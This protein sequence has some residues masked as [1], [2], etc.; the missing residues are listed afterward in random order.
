[1]LRVPADDMEMGQSLSDCFAEQSLEFAADGA[2]LAST[3]F[4]DVYTTA[5]L[6]LSNSDVE[7]RLTWW[8]GDTQVLDE[9]GVT[10][11]ST[12]QLEITIV[13]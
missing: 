10:L 5:G 11:S 3:S 12:M 8:N 13:S 7:T 9:T 1:M 2:S 4:S 6:V